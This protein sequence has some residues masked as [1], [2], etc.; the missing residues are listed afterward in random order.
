MSRKVTILMVGLLGAACGASDPEP[1]GSGPTEASTPS[2]SPATTVGAEQEPQRFVEDDAFFTL[3]RMNQMTYPAMT[4]GEIEKASDLIAIG[5]IVDV[6]EGTLFRRTKLTK[7]P[8]IPSMVV[9]LEVST[10]IKGEAV[11]GHVYY[12]EVHGGALPIER[13]R[14]NLPQDEVLVFLRPQARPALDGLQYVNEG[15]GYPAGVVPRQLTNRQ[16]LLIERE[17]RVLQPLEPA[18]EAPYRLFDA[19]S[20]AEVTSALGHLKK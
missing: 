6:R 12:E 11:Q 2:P 9:D 16:G 4:T 19:R 18:T 15:S 3:I 7:N 10:M 5:R 13:Y 20:F 14:A 1:A 17:Q 8:D